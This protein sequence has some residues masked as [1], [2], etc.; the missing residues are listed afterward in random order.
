MGCGVNNAQVPT[1]ESFWFAAGSLF[2]KM[3]RFLSV[4][5]ASLGAGGHP[6]PKYKRTYE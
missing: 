5:P 3:D 1:S 2:F 4:G 6:V